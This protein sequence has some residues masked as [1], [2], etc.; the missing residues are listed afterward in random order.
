MIH[1][2]VSKYETNKSM[3]KYELLYIVSSQYTDAEI[4][5]IQ[6]QVASE[7][8]AVG[9]TIVSSQ[10]LGKIKLAYPIRRQWHGSYI[11][12]YF[13]A[14]S[15]AISALERKLTLTDEVLR[16]TLTARKPDIQKMAFELTS[17]IAPLSEEARRERH[18][19]HS[20]ESARPIPRRKVDV[21][22]P[23]TPSSTSH[24]EKKM[25]I[26]E[27]DKKLDEMLDVDITS[28]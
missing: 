22:P 17:Y 12:T 6:E 23:P 2:V 21:L 18:K 26:E 15:S 19:D 7:V 8:T 25:S 14:E 28:L 16:H 10:N 1:V 20:E 9:G 13:D 3:N 4:E 24:E 27:L 11:L 5:K